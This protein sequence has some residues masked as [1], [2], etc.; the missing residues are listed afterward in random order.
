MR[1]PRT[2]KN[3]ELDAPGQLRLQ[4]GRRVQG[5]LPGRGENSAREEELTGFIGNSYASWPT[6]SC[7]DG[8]V[9]LYLFLER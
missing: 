1:T 9:G 2:T 4:A 8:D 6:S 5:L 7:E 3:N